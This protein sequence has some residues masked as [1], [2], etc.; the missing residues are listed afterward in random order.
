[1]VILEF[2]N[3]HTMCPAIPVLTV[4][5]KTDTKCHNISEIQGQ[6]TEDNN[7]VSATTI[8]AET[9]INFTSTKMD[10]KLIH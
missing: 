2:S 8:I 10:F 9:V 6:T 3:A 4:S 1:M 7:R 5:L